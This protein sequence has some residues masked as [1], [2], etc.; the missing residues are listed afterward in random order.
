MKTTNKVILGMSILAL[1]LIVLNIYF[2]I[3]YQT[4]ITITSI[5]ATKLIL[6]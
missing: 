5:P 6:R 1:F 2:L 4:K 3:K